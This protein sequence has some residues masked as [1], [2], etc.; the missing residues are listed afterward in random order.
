MSPEDSWTPNRD[1]RSRRAIA[2]LLIDSVQ[3]VIAH[4]G[5]S[6]NY[7]SNPQSSQSPLPTEDTGNQST[8]INRIIS[9]GWS[10]DRIHMRYETDVSARMSR[11]A[12]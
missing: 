12:Q 7:L 5:W 9:V 3:G 1:G 11:P 2:H 8:G 4:A 6:L 10:L